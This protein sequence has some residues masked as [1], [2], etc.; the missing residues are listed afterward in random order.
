[1]IFGGLSG[2]LGNQALQDRKNGNSKP[3][4]QEDFTLHVDDKSKPP[5]PPQPKP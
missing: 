2:F 1:M 4:G 3:L 5:D